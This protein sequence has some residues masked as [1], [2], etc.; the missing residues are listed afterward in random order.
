MRVSGVVIIF[1]AYQISYLECTDITLYERLQAFSSQYE[2]MKWR[3]GERIDLTED[4]QKVDSMDMLSKRRCI[5]IEG[6]LHSILNSSV[7][8]MRNL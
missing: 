7:P 3:P 2:V 1:F 4:G 6:R 8:S 5:D